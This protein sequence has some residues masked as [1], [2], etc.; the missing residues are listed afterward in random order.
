MLDWIG[1]AFTS[2]DMFLHFFYM[3]LLIDERMPA[4]YES[5]VVF[6]FTDTLYLEE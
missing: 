6:P 3:Y 2:Q 5:G 4:D 1:I